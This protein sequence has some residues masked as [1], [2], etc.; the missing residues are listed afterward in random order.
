MATKRELL[1]PPLLPGEPSWNEEDAAAL[2]EF[3]TSP[4]GQRFLRLMMY[5][6]TLV[7]ERKDP[8]V[9]RIQSDE[10]AGF[11][12]GIAEILNIAES[13]PISQLDRAAQSTR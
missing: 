1:L 11:E 13:K 10:R 6:R 4:V 2:R 3:I 12:A 8:E 5:R 9:R 7:S